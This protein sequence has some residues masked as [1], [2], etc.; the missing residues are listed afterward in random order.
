MIRSGL[1][2]LALK[3]A[4]KNTFIISLILYALV[5]LPILIAD[6]Y[7]VDDWGRVAL[8]YTNWGLDGRP[9]TD[10]VISTLDLGK[11]LVDFSPL[12]QIGAIVCLSWLGAVV[13][14]KF[15]ITRPLTAALTTLPLGANPFF[16]ANLS[17]KFD[18]LPM[19]LSV[20]LAVAPVV[21]EDA[22]NRKDRLSLLIGAILLLA[23]LCLYQPSLNAFLVFA[24]LEYLL[25]QKKGEASIIIVLL[26]RRRIFQLLIAILA[27]KLVAL[28][29]IHEEYSIKHSLLISGVGGL[30]ILWRNLV[31]FWSL[32]IGL[33]TGQLR[34]NLVLPIVLALIASIAVGL[35][36]SSQTAKS[37]QFFWIGAA[38]LAPIFM[39]LGTFGILIFL[40]SPAGGV[41]TFIGF[42]ALLSSSLI[43][44]FSLLTEY[45]V[46]GRLQCGLLIIPAYTMITFSA[47]YANATKA[48]KHYEQHIAETLSDDLKAVIAGKQV[49]KLIIDGTVGYAPVVNRIIAKRYRL[50][51]HL[52]PIDL[53]GLGGFGY[54]VL[55]YLGIYLPSE[56][57]DARRSS[58]VAETTTSTPLRGNAY[59][60]IFLVDQDLVVRLIP[61][62][63]SPT[64]VQKAGI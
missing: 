49:Q 40:Q 56:T 4:E 32:P 27:Y 7:H 52:V 48:Q 9:L 15:E 54:I 12:C 44:I 29:T 61:S 39:L 25:L 28:Y 26:L 45:N 43:L 51:G 31:A 57:S 8:G 11:P 47:I 22:A 13:A 42:G 46:P 24:V 59:Y 16:L 2:S 38:F 14:R 10:I 23:S 64:H 34:S 33:L 21:L 30:G 17:F 18:S 62:T 3:G 20:L 41:R 55:R 36:Y 19:A 35:R 53:G 6:R 50:I 58:I 60:T 37:S 5:L 63:L 1:K